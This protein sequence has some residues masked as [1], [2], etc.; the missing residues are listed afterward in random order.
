MT[1]DE[2]INDLKRKFKTL[3]DAILEERNKSSS[4]TKE[5]DKLA[6]ELSQI[7]NKFQEKVLQTVVFKAQETLIMQLKME[8]KDLEEK[9]VFERAK[10]EVNSRIFNIY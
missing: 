9:L 10:G 3:K 7:K 6:E 4:V 8:K 5:K 1:K 2:E